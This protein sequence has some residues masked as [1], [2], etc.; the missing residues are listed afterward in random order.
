LPDISDVSG[1]VGIGTNNPQYTLDVGNIGNG[2]TAN[3]ID[4][5]GLGSAG[6]YVEANYSILFDTPQF[7]IGYADY[8]DVAHQLD[9]H[10]DINFTGNLLQNGSTYV[11]ANAAT[12]SYVSGP[13]VATTLMQLPYSSSTHALTPGTAV[14]SAYFKV[15]GSL[16]LLYIYNGTAWHSASL[17]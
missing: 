14:G 9:V 7:G 5:N 8:H 3:Y 17:A 1:Q 4:F 12:S 15:S 6:I 13:V 16:N 11:P 10:G 2:Y